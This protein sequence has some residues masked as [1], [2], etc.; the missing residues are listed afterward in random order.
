M[1]RRH[2][3]V[4]ASRV[5][6]GHP[7]RRV[8]DW[9]RPAGASDEGPGWRADRRRPR[10]RS[11][12]HRRR[13]RRRR[14]RALARAGRRRWL[15]G[16]GVGRRRRLRRWVG[17]CTSG[18]TGGGRLWSRTRRWIGRRARAGRTSWGRHQE[19]QQQPDEKDLAQP[20]E[21]QAGRGAGPPRHGP[22]RCRHQLIPRTLRKTYG[23]HLSPLSPTLPC[24][25]RL[26]WR[27]INP[28]PIPQRSP[29]A[30]RRPTTGDRPRMP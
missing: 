14:D 3:P 5:R 26:K 13:C 15:S 2:H 19:R 17:R 11:R 28:P 20:R 8:R 24:K 18:R 30:A 6:D 23:P 9:A 12:R 16:R 4:Q 25:I 1:R 7:D 10:L 27:Q 22:S 29:F 21:R